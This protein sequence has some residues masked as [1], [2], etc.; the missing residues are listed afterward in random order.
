MFLIVK[1]FTPTS[2]LYKA[3]GFA[4]GA[5]CALFWA[6]GCSNTLNCENRTFSDIS[7]TSLQMSSFLCTLAIIGI[8]ICVCLAWRVK[9]FHE[10]MNNLFVCRFSSRNIHWPV[11][12]SSFSHQDLLN[13]AIINEFCCF[14]F[15]A[16]ML[17][18]V[19]SLAGRHYRGHY[20]IGRMGATSV[21]S[22]TFIYR[23]MKQ[24]EAQIH[25]LWLRID[26]RIFVVLYMLFDL[27]GLL[28][29]TNS[30]VDF[31]GHLGGSLFGLFYAVCGERLYRKIFP[32]GHRFGDVRIE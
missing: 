15:A 4:I 2:C 3:A 28:Y 25:L 19:A 8:N 20:K 26:G 1:T 11:L 10:V 14:Y 31:A 30:S 16:G 24:P 18:S 7:S 29:F 17:G 22:A 9:Y 13:M 21:I 12:L 27:T 6:L 5:S 23:L 32:A